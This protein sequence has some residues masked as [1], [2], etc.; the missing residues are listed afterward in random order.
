M[1]CVGWFSLT[2]IV[3][4][5]RGFFA[6]GKIYREK[7]VMYEQKIGKPTA[8]PYNYPTEKEASRFSHT[9]GVKDVRF[10]DTE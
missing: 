8:S 4:Q 3:P 10:A 5:G 9:Q 1:V 6:G 7:Q 2:A